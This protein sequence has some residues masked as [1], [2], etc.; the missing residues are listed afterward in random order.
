MKRMKR[1]FSFIGSIM[2]LNK[3]FLNWLTQSKKM[4]TTMSM[5]KQPWSFL[6]IFT[7]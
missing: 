4:K 3:L 1:K 6:F 7:S 5:V 2:T